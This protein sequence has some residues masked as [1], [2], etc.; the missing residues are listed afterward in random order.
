MNGRTAEPLTSAI[1]AKMA[2]TVSGFRICAIFSVTGSWQDWTS[3]KP[4]S[5]WRQLFPNP[6]GGKGGGMSRGSEFRSLS[7]SSTS[8]SSVASSRSWSRNRVSASLTCSGRLVLR[9]FTGES[10][11]KGQEARFAERW[12]ACRRFSSSETAGEPWPYHQRTM[13]VRY[14]VGVVLR[15]AARRSISAAMCSGTEGL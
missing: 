15:G 10:F 13:A 2:T 5:S 8:S 4:R 6:C 12:S 14:S 9:W 11:G 7:S 1:P 3:S